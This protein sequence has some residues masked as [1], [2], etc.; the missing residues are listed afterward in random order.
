VL[1]NKSALF[2]STLNEIEALPIQLPRIP[3]KAF[4]EVYALDG[5]STDGTL[6]F[7]AKNGIKVVKP[8]KKGAIFNVGAMSTECEYLVFFAPDGNEN[9]DDILTLLNGLKDGNDMVIASRFIQGGINEEDKELFKWRKWVSGTFNFLV[10]IRWGGHI[11]DTINGF[12]SVRRSKLIAMNP[13]PTGFD[14][15]FQMSIRALKLGHKVAEIPTVEGDRLG[16]KSVAHSFPTGWLILRR[17]LKEFFTGV[18]PPKD[19][20]LRTTLA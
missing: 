16:G 6:E 19:G 17:Y 4:D 11:T 1:N 14:I 7:Y 12:R 10:H 9:P 2:I 5:G 20:K 8:V 13:E 15:E 18:K 3:I